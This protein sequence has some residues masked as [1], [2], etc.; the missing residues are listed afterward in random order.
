MI[1]DFRRPAPTAE[2]SQE[3]VSLARLND[4]R[5]CYDVI[6]MA[7]VRLATPS[8]FRISDM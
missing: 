2:R 5:S 8:F 3:R 6:V 7:C 1:P 4:T